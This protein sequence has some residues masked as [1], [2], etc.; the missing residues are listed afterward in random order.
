MST[1]APFALSVQYKPSARLLP[2][3]T[4]AEQQKKIITLLLPAKALKKHTT[5]LEAKYYIASRRRGSILQHV[6]HRSQTTAQVNVDQLGGQQ[7]YRAGYVV[8][9]TTYVTDLII[10]TYKY[11]L[12]RTACGNITYTFVRE[13]RA[14]VRTAKIVF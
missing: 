4:T 8:M 13:K 14:E 3:S 12:S 11:T 2:I 6:L 10:H 9:K 5:H 1:E 7:T